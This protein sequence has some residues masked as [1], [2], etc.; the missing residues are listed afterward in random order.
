[1]GLG[2]SF[3]TCKMGKTKSTPLA[4]GGQNDITDSERRGA[5]Q[6]WATQSGS[7]NWAKAQP[8]AK[9]TSALPRMRSKQRVAK[10]IFLGVYFSAPTDQDL[11]S[12]RHPSGKAAQTLV[13]SD[14]AAWSSLPCCQYSPLLLPASTGPMTTSLSSFYPNFGADF[15]F[16][17]AFTIHRQKCQGT[18][19]GFL[20]VHSGD[21]WWKPL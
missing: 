12:H 9:E 11:G 17:P 6:T 16:L 4:L 21:G 8:S 10:V 19:R 5:I 14:P 13:K 3:F 7:M 2:L 20:S 1:M 18:T 15:I